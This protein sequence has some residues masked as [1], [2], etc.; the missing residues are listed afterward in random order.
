M[1]CKDKESVEKSIL[2]RE[3]SSACVELLVYLRD[4]DVQ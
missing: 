4:Y 3:K 2:I 1:K